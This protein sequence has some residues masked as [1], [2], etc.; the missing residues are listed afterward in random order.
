MNE[1]NKNNDTMNYYELKKYALWFSRYA[2]VEWF[3]NIHF[4][5]ISEVKFNGLIDEDDINTKKIRNMMIQ[6][7]L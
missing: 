1:L 3:P 2:T 7:L 6:R 4:K 5:K